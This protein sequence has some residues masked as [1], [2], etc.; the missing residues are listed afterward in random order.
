MI[1][2]C[3]EIHEARDQDH[4]YWLWIVVGFPIHL[5]TLCGDFHFWLRSLEPRLDYNNDVG[6]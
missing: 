4:S 3:D 1:L 2:D 6:F 5:V